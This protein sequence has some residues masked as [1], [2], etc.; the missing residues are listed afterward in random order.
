MLHYRRALVALA[1]FRHDGVVHHAERD[2]VDQVLWHFP[3]RHVRRVR[4]CE[5]AGEVGEFGREGGFDGAVFVGEI[6]GRQ[7]WGEGVEARKFARG[8]RAQGILQLGQQ[9]APPA[10]PLAL[11]CLPLFLFRLQHE[12]ADGAGAAGAE[13]QALVV[14]GQGALQGLVGMVEGELGLREDVVGL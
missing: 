11:A 6:R 2:A 9:C 1:R 12:A 8:A 4:S 7:R 13:A 3:P 10:Q 5:D 14:G